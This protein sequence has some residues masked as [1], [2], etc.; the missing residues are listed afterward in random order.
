MR[1]QFDIVLL[2]IVQGGTGGMLTALRKKK[3]KEKRITPSRVCIKNVQPDIMIHHRIIRNGEA[4]RRHY[5][6]LPG[7]PQSA[8]LFPYD[9]SDAYLIQNFL[10]FLQVDEIEPKVRRVQLAQ[11]VH[12]VSLLL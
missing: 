3:G 1:S 6:A 11:G 10:S 12:S 2:L 9:S 5:L 8:T 7:N 4:D